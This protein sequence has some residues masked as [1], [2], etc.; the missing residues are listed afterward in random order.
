MVILSTWVWW[1]IWK[2]S[3]IIWMLC[4][5]TFFTIYYLAH[6]FNHKHHNTYA[7]SYFFVKWQNIFPTTIS[8][9]TNIQFHIIIFAFY[10]TFCVY[11]LWHCKST[12]STCSA[13]LLNKSVHIYG[14]PINNCIFDTLELTPIPVALVAI[15][16]RIFP[17]S[18]YSYPLSLTVLH[19]L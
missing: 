3:L 17:F 16:T 15:R 4:W 9:I 12:I 7:C 2:F 13:I 18:L 14:A 1:K 6:F 10:I 8:L 19:H 5:D 11:Q